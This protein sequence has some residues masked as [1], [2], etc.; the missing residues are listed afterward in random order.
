MQAEPRFGHRAE[1]GAVCRPRAGNRG[2]TQ[3][4]HPVSRQQVLGHTRVRDDAIEQPGLQ[5]CRRGSGSL[6]AVG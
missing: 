3:H 4:A 1:L 2:R 5:G 6:G